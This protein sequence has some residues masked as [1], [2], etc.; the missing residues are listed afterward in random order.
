MTTD[1]REALVAAAR[2]DGTLVSRAFL[3]LLFPFSLIG[4][5]IDLIDLPILVPVLV[6]ALVVWAAAIWWIVRT[7]IPLEASQ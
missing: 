6:G 2:G 4:T 7:D 1:W 5:P 3:F